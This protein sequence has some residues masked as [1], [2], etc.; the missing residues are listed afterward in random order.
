MTF[1][2]HCVALVLRHEGG[3]YLLEFTD[4]PAEIVSTGSRK[5]KDIFKAFMIEPP[6]FRRHLYVALIQSSVV[7]AAEGRD[8][9]ALA[10]SFGSPAGGFLPLHEPP[11]PFS[12]PVTI[13]PE[14]IDAPDD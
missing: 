13:P 12:P 11:L 5:I 4:R 10:R 3:R 2:V 9:A 6:T 14:L 8:T 1:S 7:A